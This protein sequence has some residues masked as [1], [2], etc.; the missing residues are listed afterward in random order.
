MQKITQMMSNTTH[1][2]FEP[3]TQQERFIRLPELLTFTSLSRAS[4]YRLMASDSDFP[5]P[6]KLGGST[7][8]NAAVGF[9]LSEVQ[10]W[11]EKRANNR[12]M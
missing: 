4:A 9:S 5:K 3:G 12:G 2:Q 7:A 8:R 10:R 6:I 11:I 1:S